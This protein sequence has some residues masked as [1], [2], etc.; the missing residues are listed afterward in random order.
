M[1]DTE[2]E[3]LRKWLDLPATKKAMSFLEAKRPGVFPQE[4]P[5]DVRLYQLQGWELYRN[6]LLTLTHVE[7]DVN[8]IEES[9][10]SPEF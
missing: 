7:K 6:N 5:A 2:R 10:Q 9:F 1:T 8:P 4:T 3:E